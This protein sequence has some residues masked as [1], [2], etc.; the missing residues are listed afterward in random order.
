MA[1]S[2]NPLDD[3]KRKQRKKEKLKNKTKRITERDT[4]VAQTTSLSTVQS[5]IQNLTQKQE[6]QN[7]HLDNKDTRKLERQRKELKIVIAAEEERKKQREELE[8][9][10]WEEEKKRMKTKEGVDE[11]NQNKFQN[12][13]ASIYYD[14]IMNPF[15]APPPGRPMM[16]H[17]RGGGKTMDVN[18]AF[19]PYEL[20]DE[21]DDKSVDLGIEE[22]I[23]D[24]GIGNGS[25]QV[26]DERE[27]Q[28]GVELEDIPLQPPPPP[29]P[30]PPRPQHFH[31]NNHQPPRDYNQYAPPPPLPKVPLPRAPPPPPPLPSSKPPPMQIGPP[32]LPEPS[33]SVK[34][35]LRQQA[36]NKKSKKADLMADIWASQDE[37]N[38]EGGALEGAVENIENGHLHL[39]SQSSSSNSNSKQRFQKKRKV[40]REDVYDPLCPAD[41]GYSD[42]RSKDQI[43][44]STISKKKAKVQEDGVDVDVDVDSSTLKELKEKVECQWYYVDQSGVI[45]GPFQSEQMS[46]WGQAGFFPNDT[47]VRNGEDGEFVEMGMV[48]LLTGTLKYVETP[49]DDGIEAR[50]AMLKQS[51]Q[52]RRVESVEDRIAALKQ[53]MV[54]RPVES[55]E[56]RI[57]ALKQTMQERPPESIEDR[58]AALKNG[59][60]HVQPCEGQEAKVELAPAAKGFDNSPSDGC[61]QE[62]P[63]YAAEDAPTYPLMDGDKSPSY[64]VN[65]NHEVPAYPFDDDH[66]GL[67][68]PVDE[69]DEVPAYPVDEN[70]QGP[71]YPVDENNE[72]PTYPVVENDEIPAYSVDEND[73]GPA[74]PVD[75]NDDETAYPVDENDEVPAYPIHEEDV[76]YPTDVEY[77]IDG[78][79]AYPNTDDAYNAAGGKE[80][81][82]YFI[83]DTEEGEQ[84]V[85]TKK[86]AIFKGDKEVVGLVPAN[87]QVRRNMKAKPKKK[88]KKTSST[89]PNQGMPAQPTTE[90]NDGEGTSSSKAVADDYEKFM[91]EINTF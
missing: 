53:S 37:I 6:H 73:Q 22:K 3:Y 88:K 28:G 60:A 83:P 76:P 43:Q 23:K 47:M 81:A 51:I 36:K 45:Q 19:V 26:M 9:Q 12:A 48:D 42:Y 77:P 10:E 71:A 72:V 69:N 61:I 86:K 24:E 56:D 58:I 85:M 49:V 44:R 32:S 84:I 68:Y 35:L 57:A 74:Y 79:D 34:R 17:R 55:V 13:K 54:E 5:E 39:Q 90:V 64:P 46:G 75:E 8:K 14:P 62:A 20:R 30:P 11:L 67:A 27:K 2:S 70:D 16:Y 89:Q 15:G 50:I 63:S 82:P 33:D 59:N 38:Y 66:E 4:K 25:D 80:V 91:S 29:P 41:K 21:S 18:E 78:E 7:G 1:K 31:I 65:D 52:E 87:L 40:E